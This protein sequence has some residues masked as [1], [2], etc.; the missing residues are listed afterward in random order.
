MGSP[1]IWLNGERQ[2]AN[3]LILKELLPLARAGLK[4]VGIAAEDVDR[5][6]GTIEERVRMDQTGSQWALRALTAL[7]C[8]GTREAQHRCLTEA[9]LSNQKTGR[10]V[11]TWELPV[12]DHGKTAKEKVQDIMSTD[13]FTVQPNSTVQLVANIIDWRH[14]RHVLVEDEEGKFCGL[15]S[16]R[17]L[18]HVLASADQTN[19]PWVN[20]SAK[21]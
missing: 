20:R 5:Y 14:I 15:V 3:T 11:H 7:D 2:P 10:P 6:L 12:S 16:H 9:M 21:L 4:E 1:F 19:A 18:L 13:L 17:D 8:E